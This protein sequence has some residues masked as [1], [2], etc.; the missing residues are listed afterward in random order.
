MVYYD[1]FSSDA[2]LLALAIYNFKVTTFLDGL[3]KGKITS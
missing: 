1:E 2:T 3:I